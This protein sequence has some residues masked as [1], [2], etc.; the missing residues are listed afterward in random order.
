VKAQVVLGGSGQLVDMFQQYQTKVDQ[1]DDILIKAVERHMHEAEYEELLGSPEPALVVIGKDTDT[2]PGMLQVGCSKR[3]IAYYISPTR[4]G[5]SY[6]ILFVQ[7]YK[8]YAG[9]RTTFQ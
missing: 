2:A 3:N 7:V 5:V 1:L 8:V 4:I 9:I 6:N